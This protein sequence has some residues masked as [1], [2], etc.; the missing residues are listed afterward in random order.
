M[1]IMKTRLLLLILFGV[2]FVNTS[3]LANHCGHDM[4]RSWFYSKSSLKKYDYYSQTYKYQKVKKIM[5]N[6][7]FGLSKIKLIKKLL[8]KE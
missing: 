4:D 6:I 5:Q 2:F 7:K 1:L 3:S 8:L